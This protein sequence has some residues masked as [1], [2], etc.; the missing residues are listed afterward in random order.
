MK[1]YEIIE[2]EVLIVEEIKGKE[3]I[4]MVRKGFDLFNK[5]IATPDKTQISTTETATILFDWKKFDIETEKHLPD[6]E[7]QIPFQAEI[8][9]PDGELFSAEKIP[10]DETLEFSSE[11]AGEYTIRTVNELVGNA[12]IKV[13]VTNA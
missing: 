12:E 11:E 10:V 1:K 8:Y 13:V 9:K 4:H 2:H 3:K 7:N 5:I 6:S